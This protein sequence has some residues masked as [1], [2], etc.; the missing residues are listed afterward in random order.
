MPP[1]PS[2]PPLLGHAEPSLPFAHVYLSVCV[3]QDTTV[4]LPYYPASQPLKVNA[5]AHPTQWTTRGFK[6][7][8]VS[9]A[10]V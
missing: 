8:P 7:M 1:G 10:R 6:R 5:T 3:C 9:G 2:S 4:K